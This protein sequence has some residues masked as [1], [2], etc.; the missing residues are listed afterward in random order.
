QQPPG[1]RWRREDARS[2]PRAYP[3]AR[4]TTSAI[5]RV[6][7]RGLAPGSVEAR[8]M[9]PVGDEDEL[10]LAGETAAIGGVQP[11][12]FEALLR[13]VAR[14]PVEEAISITSDLE[15]GM[16]LAGRFEVVREIGRGGFARVFEARDRVLSRPV[17]I[18][19]LKR[20]RRL[21][22]SELELF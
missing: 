2:P 18:K 19:L 5:D 9:S 21:D 10:E 1:G 11:S 7:E 3:R 13:Q 15:A 22:D 14:A 6:I 4:S 16:A 12:A 20:Y 8:S 17:A